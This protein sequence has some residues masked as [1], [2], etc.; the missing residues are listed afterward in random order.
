MT[1]HRLVDVLEVS[2]EVLAR[3][4]DMP[5]AEWLELRRSG[6][7]GSD[8]AAA[9]GLSPWVSPVALWVEKTSPVKVGDDKP[10]FEAGR[11]MEEPIA[12]WFSD[13]SGLPIIELPVMLR[14]RTHPFMLGN[15][16][17][18]M[19]EDD[20]AYSILE[21]KNVDGRKAAEWSV[22]PPLHYRIQLLTYLFVC[23]LQRGYFAALIGGN[24]FRTFAIERD[25]AMIADIVAGCEKFWTLVTLNR[26]PDI[27]GTDSTRDALKAHYAY[28]DR[29]EV[30]VSQGFVEL[31]HQRHAAKAVAEAATARLTEIENRIKGQIGGAEVARFNGGVVATWKIQSK[32]E[33]TVKASETRVLRIP[34]KKEAA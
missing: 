16:D 15:P 25:D 34:P 20:G 6:V 4:D 8:A 1:D 31:L 28:P 7:G 18:F 11:R 23:G 24:D 5:R 9:L 26:M 10:I 33:Y 13:S 12:K 3:T 32:K 22:G 21:C 19:L 29:A 14:S 17:R 27:D 2:A 30:E